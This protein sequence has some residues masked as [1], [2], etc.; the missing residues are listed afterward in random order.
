MINL[1]FVLGEQWWTLHI[2]CNFIFLCDFIIF[3]EQKN[4]TY[5]ILKFYT[6][7][8]YNIAHI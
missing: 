8:E 3:T 7:I 4:T 5:F 2:K 1:G 6:I